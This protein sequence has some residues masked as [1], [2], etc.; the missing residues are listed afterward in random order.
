VALREELGTARVSFDSDGVW[1]TDSSGLEWS[2]E[3]GAWLSALGKELGLEYD[4]AEIAH[5]QAR[6]APGGA[7]VDVG[8]HVGG[9]SMPVAA[10]AEQVEIHAFEPVPETRARLIANLRRNGLQ[11]GVEVWDKAVG[12]RPGRQRITTST[13]SGE[14]RLLSDER[15]AEGAS[16]EVEVVTLDR[17]LFDRCERVDV[18]KCDI[19]G[20]ELDAL[21]GGEQLLRR[22]RPDVLAELDVRFSDRSDGGPGG[23]IAYMTELGYEC[24]RFADGELREVGEFGGGTNNLLFTISARS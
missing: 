23:L 7:F 16:V 1:I 13:Q 5:V 14:N 3:P 10:A 2:Y 20:G 24:R 12:D 8:A 9:Y 11:D 22:D 17:H 21:R 4:P 18:I 15:G 19:E 6:L